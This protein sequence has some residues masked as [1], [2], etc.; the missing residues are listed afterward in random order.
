M[1]EAYNLR[2]YQTKKF[3]KIYQQLKESNLKITYSVL[4]KS[5]D[6]QSLL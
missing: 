1:K 5:R 6:Q 2:D 4:I 3:I